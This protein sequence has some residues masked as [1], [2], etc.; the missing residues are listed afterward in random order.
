MAPDKKTRTARAAR[1]IKANDN[2][3]YSTW[4]AELAE[5]IESSDDISLNSRIM[6]SKNMY[7][8]L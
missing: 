2:L 6:Y 3:R 7:A 1:I 5:L 4:I 8:R